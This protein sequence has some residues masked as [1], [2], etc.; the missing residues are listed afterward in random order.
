[1]RI[2]QNDGLVAAQDH[3][4]QIECF[5]LSDGRRVVIERP[6]DY[7]APGLPEEVLQII[8]ARNAQSNDDIRAAYDAALTAHID[9]VARSKGYE[10][11][12][13][14]AVRAAFPG[15]WQ[16]E[17]IAFGQWMDQCNEI[18]YQI[19]AGVQTGQIELPSLE[20]FI[21]MLPPMQWPE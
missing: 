16:Q 10:D 3:R 4:P 21:A 19:V 7:D 9:S 17:G 6:E 2:F 13:S 5:I 12:I 20:E 18:G 15:P 14:C 1:M 8:A 11:R